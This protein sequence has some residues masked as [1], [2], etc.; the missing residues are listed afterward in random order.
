MQDEFRHPRGKLAMRYFGDT[1][2]R[3]KDGKQ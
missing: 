2:Q 1:L 3:T